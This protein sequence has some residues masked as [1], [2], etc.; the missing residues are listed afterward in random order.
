[1]WDIV[2]EIILDFIRFVPVFLVIYIIVGMI[3]G[4]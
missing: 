2:L 4:R 1:M 3:R